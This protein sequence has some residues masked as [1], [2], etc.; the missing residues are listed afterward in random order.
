M[1]IFCIWQTPDKCLADQEDFPF[2]DYV[3]GQ[4]IPKPK[5][6]E[7]ALSDNSF[8]PVNSGDDSD[9]SI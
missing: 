4:T 7:P 1:T 5:D 8:T 9:F 2:F 3:I 6:L